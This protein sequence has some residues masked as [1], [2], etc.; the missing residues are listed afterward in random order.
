MTEDNEQLQAFLA[1]M[2]TGSHD[3]ELDEIDAA[4]HYRR[5]VIARRKA[6]SLKPGDKVRF[7]NGRPKYL[8]GLLA[9]VKRADETHV[10]VDIPNEPAY[11]RFAG[12]TDVRSPI[13]IIEPAE[14]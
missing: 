2:Q 4:L 14:G 11:K 10:W 9:T 1:A 6:S 13:G 8:N 12:S 5:S 3:A 7:T